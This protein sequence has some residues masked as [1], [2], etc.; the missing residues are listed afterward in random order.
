MGNYIKN[1]IYLYF[2]LIINALHDKCEAFLFANIT[3]TLH[4]KRYLFT[5]GYKDITF[6]VNILYVFI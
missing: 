3:Q 6:G 1:Y 2:Y 4:K 5:N